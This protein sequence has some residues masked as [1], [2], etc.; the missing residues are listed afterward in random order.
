MYNKVLKFTNKTS[1]TFVLYSE[2][3]NIVD[4]RKYHYIKGN[5][6]FINSKFIYKQEQIPRL[7]KRNAN[8][9]PFF[10]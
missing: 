4:V 6:L 5:A 8:S 7:Y 1:Y 2:H 9:K 10:A 3:K